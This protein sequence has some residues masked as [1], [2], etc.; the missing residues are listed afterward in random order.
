MNTALFRMR[1][2]LDG[3]KVLVVSAHEKMIWSTY[4]HQHIDIEATLYETVDGKRKGTKVF[5]RGQLYCG[6]NSSTCIDSDDAKELVLSTLAMCP[7]HTDPDYFADY[8]DE[9]LA[10]VEQYGEQIG[11]AAYYRFGGAND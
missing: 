2:R 9:Q 10:F 5:P 7:G 3:D 6:V 8:T 4:G 11:V 1:V